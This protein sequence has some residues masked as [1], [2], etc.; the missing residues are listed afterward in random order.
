MLTISSPGLPFRVEPGWYSP[1]YGVRERTAFIRARSAAKEGDS[2]H[3]F[4]STRLALFVI[5]LAGFAIRLAFVASDPQPIEAAGLS[6]AMGQIAHNILEGHWF[7]LNDSAPANAKPNG[8]VLDPADADWGPADANG[9]YRPYS[10]HMQGVAVLLA[11]VWGIT[12]DEDYI[13]LQVIQCLLG[14]LTSLLAWWIVMRLYGRP[15]AAMIAAGL[16][17]VHLRSRT[18]CGS[19]TTRRGRP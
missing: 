7:Q 18:S 5:V 2:I 6:G 8:D 16:Y 15:R 19:R 10:L 3:A 14:A 11:G 12:G 13:Y 1:R 9:G 17:A 4:R